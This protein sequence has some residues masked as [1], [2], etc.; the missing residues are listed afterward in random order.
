[1][2]SIDSIRRIPVATTPGLYWVRRSLPS[3]EKIVEPAELTTQGNWKPLGD[4]GYYP[5]NSPDIVPLRDLHIPE[6]I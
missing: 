4:S 6:N 3:G 5:A 1:M 2:I